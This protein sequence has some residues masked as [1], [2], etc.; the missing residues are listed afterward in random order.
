MDSVDNGMMNCD[1]FFRDWKLLLL[2]HFP[3]HGEEVI[4][5]S[6]SLEREKHTGYLARVRWVAALVTISAES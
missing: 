3:G 6:Q 4:S 5:W 1:E 2:S